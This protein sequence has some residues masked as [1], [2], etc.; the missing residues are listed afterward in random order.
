MPNGRPL[1]HLVMEPALTRHQAD[2]R[3]RA[4]AAEVAA[5]EARARGAPV[6]ANR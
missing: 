4:L 5:D 6:R 3:V 2:P 1:A